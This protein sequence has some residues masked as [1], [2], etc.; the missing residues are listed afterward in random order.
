MEFFHKLSYGEGYI[1]DVTKSLAEYPYE[2]LKEYDVLIMPNA[3]PWSEAERK[4]L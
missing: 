1:L 2:K 3:A 4:A